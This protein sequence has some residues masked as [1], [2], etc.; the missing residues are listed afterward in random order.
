[1]YVSSLWLIDWLVVVEADH[2]T[3]LE[4]WS[5][6]VIITILHHACKIVCCFHWAII[7]DLSLL[8]VIIVKRHLNSHRYI[9]CVAAVADVLTCAD[10][11]SCATLWD[12][13]S[14]AL[15]MCHHVPL[16]GSCLGRIARYTSCL[17]YI[18][19]IIPWIHDKIVPNIVSPIYRC[20][21]QISL[22]Y[23]TCHQPSNIF[24]SNIFS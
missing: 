3:F 15:W 19:N 11:P 7:Y 6:T 17:R 21:P 9:H 13:P 2:L 20:Q 14:C 10:V 12:V 22:Y 24:S 18:V 23:T 16:C 5:P 4:H 1:M 8:D